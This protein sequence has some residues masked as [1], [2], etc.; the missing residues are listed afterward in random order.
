MEV[1]IKMMKAEKDRVWETVYVAVPQYGL[2]DMKPITIMETDLIT[3]VDKA[4]EYV[5][6]NPDCPLLINI[7]KRLVGG[8]ALCAT[9]E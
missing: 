4:K 7:G 8:D 2:Q 6:E 9:I 5:K 3:A 1:T